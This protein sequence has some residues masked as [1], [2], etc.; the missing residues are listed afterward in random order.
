MEMHQYQTK[1]VNYPNQYPVN[2]VFGHFFKKKQ[3]KVHDKKK[4]F[5]QK[6]K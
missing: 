3:F 2:S 4:Q 6:Q 5:K 1:F